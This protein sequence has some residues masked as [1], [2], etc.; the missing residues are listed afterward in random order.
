M[1]HWTVA[2]RLNALKAVAVLVMALIVGL[3]W[4][5]ASVL[6]RV[7][8]E[9]HKRL[10][11]AGELQDGSNLGA[12]AY[13]VVADTF[14]NRH[15]DEAATEWAKSNKSI[16]AFLAKLDQ[17]VDTT[18][19][20]EW[21]RAARAAIQQMQQLYDQ[22]FLPLAKSNAPVE[23]IRDVDDQMDKLIDQ[24][25]EL[26][27]KIA[28]SLQ[29]EADDA[30]KAYDEAQSR[31]LKVSISVALAAAIALVAFG[32]SISRGIRADLGAEPGAVRKILS[33]L[34]DGDLTVA[35]AR[36]PADQTSVVAAVDDMRK[37]LR[38]VIQ[39]VRQGSNQ[40]QTAAT[41]V[42]SG[43]QELS[44]R[45]EATASSLEQTAS[46]MEEITATVRQSA[47]A[48]RQANQLASTAATVAA[49]GGEVVDQVV[50]SMR[51]IQQSSQRIADII[52]VIDGIAFQTNIL[53][54]NAAVEAARAGEQGRGFAVVAGEV[55]SLAQRSANAAKEIK[56]LITTSVERVH[57]GT[58]QVESAGQTM[59]EIVTS[60][61]R[62][63]DIIG[64][65][66]TAAMEQSNGIS[67]VNVAVTQ[68]DQ[69]TQQN[70]TLVE[71]SAA[72]A[73]R[74]RD[75]ATRLT[76]AVSVFNTGQGVTTASGSGI[77]A[78][79]TRVVSPM[80]EP[81]KAKRSAAVSAP[82][83]SVA[84]KVL[85][86]RA[87]ARMPEQ[88]V[89]RRDTSAPTTPSRAIAPTSDGDWETF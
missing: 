9:A 21:A 36:A 23:D 39:T 88:A 49:K 34:R 58:A 51:D 31:N 62:V 59:A 25:D 14:I 19:E 83:P 12:Q 40:I 29:A 13:R 70:A 78:L 45:T 87:P 17:T 42:A 55:R 75:Q 65:I 3:S 89:A 27:K 82:R 33:S 50:G 10:L 85:P 84:Q 48:S 20:R 38:D 81:P 68:L 71:Q 41:E 57:A 16:A 79:P 24:Y 77:S 76:E 67:Q 11:E 15:F 46:S 86:A 44:S 35:I 52:S 4:Y 26:V 66:T 8:A 2:G 72:A 1:N 61:Q 22:K 6:H 60:V 74:L 53:A 56:D 80:V 7:Q 54:L 73:Q 43:N 18:Q 32:I 63:S 69:M 28:T 47:D 30:Q 5:Q 64:E 37:R